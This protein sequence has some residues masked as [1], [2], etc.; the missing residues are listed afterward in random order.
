MERAMRPFFSI[1]IPVYN[2]AHVLG[3]AL[4]SVLSQSCQDFEVVVVDDGSSDDPASVIASF[5][6]PRILYIR[7]RNCGGGAARN[8]GIDA[9]RGR[10]VAPLDSDDE[11]L[12]GHLDRMKRTLEDAANVVAYARVLVNRGKGR[13]LLKPPRAIASGEHMATYLLCDR[14]FVPTI[15]V[16]V[17]RATAHRV[18]YSEYLRF[19]EDTD[20][21][22]RLFLDG[23][24][25]VMLEEPG[26]IW[27]D[28][29]DPHR[30]SANRKGARLASWI[31]ELRPRIPAAA[32]HG[33]RGWTIA[34]GVAMTWPWQALRLYA[35]ALRHRCYSPRLAAIVFLQIFLSDA[36]YRRVA[37]VGIGWMGRGAKRRKTV[38]TGGFRGA[39]TGAAEQPLT[40]PQAVK[41]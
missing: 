2:R 36:N 20:F 13:S 25:F 1:I 32:Y 18:R 7:Q 26:A 19:G 33:C 23:N 28:L 4:A 37:D 34:K 9:A 40:V 17:D 3:R 27:H 6:D 21:A 12:P 8:A 41:I 29:R 10:F 14:G 38:P 31:E 22:I 39:L 5:A 11:F 35:T 15:T 16:T 24:R 30:A